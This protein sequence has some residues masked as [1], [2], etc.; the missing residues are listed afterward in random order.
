MKDKVKIRPLRPYEKRKL[1]RLKNQKTNVVNSRNARIVFLSRGGLRNREI[2]ERVE[3]SPQWVRVIIHRFNR[4]GIDGIIW[5]PWFAS[6]GPSQFLA[7]VREQIAE[8]ALSSPQALIGMKQWSLAKLRDYLVAQKIVAS[9]SIEWL[10][11]ILRRCKISL[12]RT[13]T[14]KESTDPDFW[15][16]YRAIRRLYQKRPANG[17]RLS[18][19]EFGPL[20]LQP[21]HGHC[22]VGRGKRLDRLRA[23]YNRKLGVRHFLAY[24]DLETNRLY[25]R[26]TKQKT[27]VQFLSFLQWVRRRYPR[28]QVL[29]IVMDNYGPHLKDEVQ[30]WAKANNIR[31]YLTPTNASWLN[32]I[33]CHFTALKKFALENSDHRTH[34]EQQDA[35]ESYLGWRN[36]RREISLQ[37]WKTYKRNMTKVPKTKNLRNAKVAD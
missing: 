30:T 31:F 15:R 8:V 5:Y 27:W 2:A 12:R 3:C 10:R 4:A 1:R 11:Q 17:R 32:R 7:D 28:E 25:G 29:H 9:I 26:F 23:T 33:E 24:Y 6:H 18:I 21:R 16:K 20:N 19:D 22:L 13:K 37:A 14:W 36:G 34:E 35:I